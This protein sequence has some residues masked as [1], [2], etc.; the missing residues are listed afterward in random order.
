MSVAAHRP[1]SSVQA[2]VEGFEADPQVCDNYSFAS[3]LGI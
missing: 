3:Q 2:Q 1:G